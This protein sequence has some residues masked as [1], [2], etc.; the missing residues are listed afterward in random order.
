MGQVPI[1]VDGMTGSGKTTLVNHLAN[2]LNL[3][4]MPEEFRDPY[5]LLYRFADDVK[6]CYP[7]Q[8]NFLMTRYIQYTVASE[9]ENYILDRSIY[10]DPVYAKLYY[11]MGYL[12][13]KQYD[14]YLNFYD[15]LEED[16]KEPKCM[17]ILNCSFDEIMRR[18]VDRGRSDELKLSK[19][20]YW[21]PLYQAYQEHV[22]KLLT[23][24]DH[25]STKVI[26]I[27]TEDIDLA[28]RDEQLFDIL[29][30]AETAI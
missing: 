4:V 7:M 29:N 17:I 19:E 25:M 2:E 5:N 12:S 22:D 28:K 9:H 13:E 1:V 26:R 14:N 23:Q 8:L 24:Q 21:W 18:I 20:G 3:E 30:L 11:N 27:D 15:S 16:I 6:W 10:S